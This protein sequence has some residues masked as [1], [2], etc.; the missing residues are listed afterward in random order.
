MRPCAILHL[1]PTWLACVYLVGVSAQPALAEAKVQITSPQD[2]AVFRPGDIVHVT[3]STS[4]AMFEG[5]VVFP[6][7]PIDVPE[8]V[9]FPPYRFSVHIARDITPGKYMLTAS[10][11]VAG[12]DSVDSETILIDIER[13]E[14]P[15]ST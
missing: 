5:V 1:V 10:A 6:E 11:A 8:P 2:G 7:D 15:L 14:D 3:V 9:N 4:G 12:G 13:P